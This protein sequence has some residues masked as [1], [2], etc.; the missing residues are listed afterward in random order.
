M[1]GGYFI[2]PLISADDLFSNGNYL[3]ETTFLKKRI[4]KFKFI[5]YTYIY[6]RKHHIAHKYITFLKL[7]Q[8]SPSPALF[9]KFYCY[10]FLFSNYKKKFLWGV[11]RKHLQS[12]KFLFLS[13]CWN[14][15]ESLN[16]KHLCVF[17]LVNNLHN[18]RNTRLGWKKN[19]YV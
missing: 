18:M 10:N 6:A 8:Y 11:K 17:L 19:S 15:K 12:L 4:L 3:H 14:L 13:V 2:C 5:N 9:K 1:I 7:I 16:P